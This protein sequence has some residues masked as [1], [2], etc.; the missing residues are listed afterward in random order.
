MTQNNKPIIY[1]ATDKAIAKNSP[2]EVLKKCKELK[3][4]NCG[5]AVL[6]VE[7]TFSDI[8]CL[9]NRTGRSLIVL[10]QSCCEKELDNQEE[11]AFLHVPDHE[12]DSQLNKHR[13]E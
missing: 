11:S 12:I 3:C 4:D 5:T 6:A 10:C 2:R 1:S 9:S 8:V 13:A 7:R